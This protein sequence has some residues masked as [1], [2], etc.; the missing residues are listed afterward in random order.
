MCQGYRILSDRPY[1]SAL[2]YCC[3]GSRKEDFPPARLVADCDIDHG[4]VYM[5]HCGSLPRMRHLHKVS[6][7]AAQHNI[8]NGRPCFSVDYPETRRASPSE[9]AS[10]LLINFVVGLRDVG[11][12][13]SPSKDHMLRRPSYSM[14][15]A[16]RTRTQWSPYTGQQNPEFGSDTQCPGPSG[17][18]STYDKQHA[19]C[20]LRR[21]WGKPPVLTRGQ[22]NK[23][24]RSR[25]PL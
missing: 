5:G 24:R 4:V 23:Q 2:G 14:E 22:I 17:L 19:P 1:K 8:L 15:L 10:L 13:A 3:A 25:A 6:G 12:F 18:I 16:N 11:G 7:T 20:S 21:S 9:T